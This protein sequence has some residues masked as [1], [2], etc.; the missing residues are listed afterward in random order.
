MRPSQPNHDSDAYYRKTMNKVLKRLLKKHFAELA[1]QESL[2]ALFESFS[3]V[4]NQQDEDRVMLERSLMLTSDELNDINHQLRTQLEEVKGVSSKLEKSAVKLEALMNASPEAII[5]FQMNGSIEQANLA[6]LEFIGLNYEQAINLTSKQ[7]LKI[8]LDRI[9]NPGE[10]KKEIRYGDATF[11]T[12]QSGYFNTNDGRHFHYQSEP[13]VFEGNTI[14]RVFCFRDITDIKKNQELLKH[15]AFHDSL[16]GLPNRSFL[17]ESLEHAIKIAKRNKHRTAVLFIDLDDFKKINDTAGHEQGD[18]F[19][20]DVSTR[21]QSTLRESDILGRLGGDEFLIILEDITNQNQAIEIH[22]RILKLFEKPFSIQGNQYV[23]TCS[24]GISL[25]PQD[26]LYPDEL[27]RKADMAMYQAKKL[28]KNTFHYF[29]DSLERIALHRVKLESDL[30]KAI[31]ENEF[32]LHFQPKVSLL[33][34]QIEGVEALIRWHKS[35][36][37]IVFP[38]RFI[39]LAEDMG[40]ITD[41]SLWVIKE[42]CQTIQRWNSPQLQDISISVNLSAID[43]INDEFIDEALAIIHDHKIDPKRIEVELTETV[44]FEN[45]HKINSALLK[46]KEQNIKISIDDF[47]TGY[48]SFSYLQSLHI[49]YLKIDKSFVMGLKDKPKSLAIVKSIIDIGSNLGLSV[50]AEGI[51]TRYELNQLMI[52]GCHMGQGYLFSKPVNEGHIIEYIE[53]K[54]KNSL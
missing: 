34:E 11:T 36:N 47:G 44:L 49:D 10:F 48:S 18:L 42:T 2:Q 25:Y 54:N 27:I 9:S 3:E 52:S 22:D 53:A 26:G 37:D 41:I 17:T 35:D 23:V 20:K 30:R 16:T 14:G 13:E 45:T 40:L 50:I 6:A 5:S 43:F 39:P 24:I 7:T 51:E 28:G 46:L 19:L 32:K 29:D 31:K 38:D 1:D 21:I 4:L 33:T 15:Q 12:K 8:F